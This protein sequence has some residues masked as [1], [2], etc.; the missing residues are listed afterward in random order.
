MGFVTQFSFRGWSFAWVPMGS[1]GLG[2]NPGKSLS[3][4]WICWQEKIRG[5]LVVLWPGGGLGSR[6]FRKAKK[7]GYRRFWPQRDISV[8]CNFPPEQW[9]LGEEI[10]SFLANMATQKGNII[11]WFF[12]VNSPSKKL[13]RV[14]SGTRN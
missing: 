13:S 4:G 10:I 14:S 1:W 11:R 7:V 6:H 2:Y 12:L 5:L 3:Y 9:F 8:C